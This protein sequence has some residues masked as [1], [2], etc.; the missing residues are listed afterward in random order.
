M[1]TSVKIAKVL[2]E[3]GCDPMAVNEAK[4]SALDLCT[5]T[6]RIFKLCV[7]YYYLF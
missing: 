3:N 6:V 2:L 4:E 7:F 1:E 5:E